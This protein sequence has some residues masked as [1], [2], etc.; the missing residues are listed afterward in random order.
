[1]SAALTKIPIGASDADAINVF[2]SWVTNR[3]DRNRVGDVI[4]E[5]ADIE[6]V[7]KPLMSF[8]NNITQGP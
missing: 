5:G 7:S 3:K 4:L 1:M 8:D 6:D 2:H